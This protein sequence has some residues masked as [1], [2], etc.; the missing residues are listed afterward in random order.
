[1][2][3]IIAG[4]LLLLSST[5]MHCFSAEN[6]VL[7]TGEFPPLE[8]ESLKYYGLVPR[9]VAEAFRLEGIAVKFEFYPWKRAYELSKAGKVNG[10][11]Q[12]FYSSIREQDHYYSDPIMEEKVVWFHLKNTPFNWYSLTDLKN[13][14]IGAI[15][16]F[17]Y[18]AEFYKA[19]DEKIFTVE[20]VTKHKQNFDKLLAHR[21]QVFPETIDVGF[22]EIQKHYPPKTAHLFTYHPKPFMTKWNYLLLPKKLKNSSFLL[23]KFNRGLQKLKESGQFQKYLLESRK[24]VYIKADHIK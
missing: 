1:M 4:I 2:K 11:V 23:G 17:T 12:W 3:N 20:F 9:I 14:K 10:S 6:I 15:R 19:V 7:S 13:K 21:I 24:G 22:Y 5:S 8:S 18:N 16:G